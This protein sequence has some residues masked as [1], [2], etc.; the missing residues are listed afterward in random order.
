[1]KAQKNRSSLTYEQ[2]GLRH[3]LVRFLAFHTCLIAF[4]LNTCHNFSV[5]GPFRLT[6]AFLMIRTYTLQ[7][8]AK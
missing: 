5:K 7:I 1:M 6:S 3:A 8:G 4:R 2:L